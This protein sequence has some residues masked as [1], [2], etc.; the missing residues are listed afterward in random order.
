MSLESIDQSRNKKGSKEE[1]KKT[2]E[3]MKELEGRIDAKT[4]GKMLVE[5]DSE[6]RKEF[7]ELVGAKR[8]AEIKDTAKEYSESPLPDDISDEDIPEN[9]KEQAKEIRRKMGM[10]IDEVTV[11]KILR[12]MSKEER[13]EFYEIIDND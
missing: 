8:F 1:E 3:I 9:I 13:E 2:A 7:K 12:N 11:S 4:A 6:D 5:M 10:K